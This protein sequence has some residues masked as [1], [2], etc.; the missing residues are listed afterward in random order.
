MADRL[1]ARSILGGASLLLA[2][3]AFHAQAQL[4]DPTRPPSASAA[5]LGGPADGPVGRQLQ[6]VLLSGGRKVAIIDGK[7]VPLGG[8][9]GEAR[10]VRISE[11]E[12][13]L[14][15]GEETEVLKLY[16]GVDKQPVKRAVSRAR[17]GGATGEPTRHG[18]SK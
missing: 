10:L 15:T 2:M 8:M 16:P 18:G 14:K 9:F 3:A 5:Q 6:S 7:T 13:T 1:N 12:V 11:T 4:A 17:T